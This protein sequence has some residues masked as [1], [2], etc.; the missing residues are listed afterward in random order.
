MGYVQN[1]NKHGQY[2]SDYCGECI[3]ELYEENARLKEALK[4][5]AI[6]GCECCTEG[7]LHRDEM[8][9][10]ARDALRGDAAWDEFNITLPMVEKIK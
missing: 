5:I 6:G 4:K 9:D 3:V 1:C 8:I 2:K 10:E 7:S